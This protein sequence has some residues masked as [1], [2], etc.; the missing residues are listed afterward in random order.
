MTD[1]LAELRQGELPASS[2]MRNDDIETGANVEDDESLTAFNRE[3]EAIDKVFIWANR[4]ITTIDD[5]LSDPDALP[6]VTSQLDSID[7]KIDAV[8]KRLKRI[9]TENKELAAAK[10][11]APA[12]LRIR[13][14]RYTKLGNEFMAVVS[15]LQDVR[16]RHRN[17][18][19]EG[20]KRDIFKA[21]PDATEAQVD[22]ALK[23]GDGNELE[24]VLASS[25]NAQ[26][27][28]QIEDLRSR[29]RDI[30]SLAKNIVE[31]HQMFTDMSILVDGQ[32]ELINNIEYNVKEVKVETR[33]AAEEL[34]E[35]RRHQKSARKK[36][37]CICIIVVVILIAIAL[38][39][40]IPVG[41]NNGWFSS[42]N[43][44]N[45]DSSNG[46][47]GST[48]VAAA[49]TPVAAAPAVST[50]PGT[51]VRRSGTGRTDKVEL[52]PRWTD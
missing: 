22:R 1:R 30:Q 38:A 32:Q 12:T 27:R 42:N 4:S 48:P 46:N 43:S 5:S 16:E 14:T 51:A 25:D 8:R 3:A 52:Q 40:I 20:V 49:P 18:T 34:V 26:V 41:V 45:N 24:A 17:L 19:T 31:L 35:A 47:G 15:S 21:N 39:I 2:S 13:V 29:N 23:N 44:N 11:I 50:A 7:Q 10:E 9:A 37:I 36:K 28:H 6:S 33:K